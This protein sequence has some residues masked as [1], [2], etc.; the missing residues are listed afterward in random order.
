LHILEARISTPFEDLLL[1]A[2]NEQLISSPT[3][4]TA[5]ILSILQYDGYVSLALMIA[6]Q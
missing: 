4:Y 3:L 5:N 1:L 6:E 2:S